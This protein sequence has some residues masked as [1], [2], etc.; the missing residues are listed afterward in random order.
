MRSDRKVEAE[1]DKLTI[2]RANNA[3]H[4]LVNSLI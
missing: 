3:G 2:I 1:T 4:L